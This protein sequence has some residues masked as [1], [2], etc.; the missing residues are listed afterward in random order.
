MGGQKTPKL[1]YL[2]QSVPPGF[3][4]DAAWTARHAI[5][6]QSVSA[7]IKQGWLERIATG[8]YRRPFS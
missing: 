4:V 5:S 1:K 8:V 3:L 7:Y 6:R 2:I